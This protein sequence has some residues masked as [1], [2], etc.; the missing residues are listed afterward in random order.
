MVSAYADV[1]MTIEPSQPAVQAALIALIGVVLTVL[2]NLLIKWFE[3]RV[4]GGATPKP[5][6]KISSSRSRPFWDEQLRKYGWLHRAHPKESGHRTRTLL[7]FIHGILG[8]PRKYWGDYPAQILTAAGEEMDVFSF[9]YNAGFMLAG[10][11]HV[12]A[13]NLQNALES[14]LPSYHEYIFVTHSAGGLVLKTYLRNITYVEG[15]PRPVPEPTAFK[16]RQL[17]LASSR[18]RAIVFAGT[19]HFGGE[20]SLWKLMNGAYNRFHSVTKHFK[21]LIN[22][23][24][25]GAVPCG[26]N[27]FPSLLRPG[28]PELV[29]LHGDFVQTLSTL[30]QREHNFITV[31]DI[32][33][34]HDEASPPLPHSESVV[35]EQET[36]PGLLASLAIHVPKH[37]RQNPPTEALLMRATVERSLDLDAYSRVA[38]LFPCAQGTIYQALLERVT[39]PPSEFPEMTTLSGPAGTGKSVILRRLARELALRYW[40]STSSEL[41]FLPLIMPLQQVDLKPTEIDRFLESGAAAWQ[42]LAEKWLDWGKRLAQRHSVDTS[43]IYLSEW[44]ERT[45]AERRALL[46]LDSV[47]EFLVKHP[48]ISTRAMNQCLLYLLKKNRGN[49]G[50]SIFIGIRDEHS[51]VHSIR[52][53]ATES[54]HVDTP[55]LEELCTQFG[56]SAELV[57]VTVPSKVLAVVMRPV[58]FRHLAGAIVKGTIGGRPVAEYLRTE[59]MVCELALRE[60]LRSRPIPAGTDADDLLSEDAQL[61]LLAMIAW[62]YYGHSE[63][64]SG[65]LDKEDVIHIA[66]EKLRDWQEHHTTGHGEASEAAVEALRRAADPRQCERYLNSSVFFP[67]DN[68][69]YRFIHDLWQDFLMG[70]YL[71]LCINAGFYKELGAVAYK[72]YVMRLGAHFVGAMRITNASVAEVVKA[73][74]T[75]GRELVFANY[76]TF[77]TVNPASVI[78]TSGLLALLGHLRQLSPPLRLVDCIALVY[79][80]VYVELPESALRGVLVDFLDEHTQPSESPDKVFRSLCYCYLAMLAPD[81]VRISADGWT[82]PVLTPEELPSQLRGL[83]NLVE[84]KAKIKAPERTTQAAFVQVTKLLWEAPVEGRA[85]AAIHYCYYLVLCSVA[86]GAT[87]DTETELTAWFRA[88]RPDALLH[89]LRTNTQRPEV[90]ALYEH[91][92]QLL[93]EGGAPKRIA[94][95]GPRSSVLPDSK[96]SI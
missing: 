61:N 85:I 93:H 41:A 10:S 35:I 60:L 33:G 81:S 54:R 62:C 24:T 7:V 8:N 19:P 73:Q 59:G 64:G 91:C 75:D 92:R 4:L 15:K 63:G 6:A 78:E 84:G 67:V 80:I 70:L 74:T 38:G 12:A 2:G 5:A 25:Q 90:I 69:S 66:N 77:V 1:A 27:E 11:V 9:A 18:L 46:I 20:E 88:D 57:R 16:Y 14:H 21:R 26:F 53:Q 44:L 58:L 40:E 48:D 94:M 28:N 30:R 83:L 76:C 55:E 23:V 71:S 87:F 51:A 89:L 95:G 47:D 52:K 43:S 79:R 86:R 34:R 96:R 49:P 22:F 29:A 36:H 56:I 39:S 82:L 32:R 3:V 65:A 68:T 17:D 45:L 50:L 42:I 37:L 13:A 72:Q 31:I